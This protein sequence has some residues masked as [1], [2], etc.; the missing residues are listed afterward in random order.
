M[1]RSV[2]SSGHCGYLAVPGR[3]ALSPADGRPDGLIEGK[4]P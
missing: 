1:E 4:P 2:S 3:H